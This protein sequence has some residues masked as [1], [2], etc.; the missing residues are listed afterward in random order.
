MAHYGWAGEGMKSREYFTLIHVRL[1]EALI[2]L[3]FWGALICVHRRRAQYLIGCTSAV[4]I[5]CIL[6]SC[7]SVPRYSKRNGALS[8][9]PQGMPGEDKVTSIPPARRRLSYH[10]SGLPPHAGG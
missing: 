7:M 9:G 2:F 10:P 6:R 5:N 1:G 8:G 3:L 4:V